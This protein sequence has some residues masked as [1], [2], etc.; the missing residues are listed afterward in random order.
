MLQ[1]GVSWQRNKARLPEHSLRS[2]QTNIFLFIYFFKFH[3][4]KLTIP[5]P[6]RIEYVLRDVQG[7]Q[8]E[9]SATRCDR[10]NNRICFSRRVEVRQSNRDCFREALVLQAKGSHNKAETLGGGGKNQ[11]RVA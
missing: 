3:L 4:K 11:G 6:S 2:V 1:E 7:R 9:P 5:A 8:S 10:I